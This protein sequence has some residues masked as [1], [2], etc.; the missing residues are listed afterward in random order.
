MMEELTGPVSS[1]GSYWQV[2]T[3]GKERGDIVFSGIT[4]DELAML[5]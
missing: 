4:T 3:A 1:Q 2:M 5:Q